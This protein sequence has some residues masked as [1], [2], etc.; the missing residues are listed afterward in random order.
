MNEYYYYTLIVPFIPK[1]ERQIIKKRD[2]HLLV[3]KS[4]KHR[5]I[6]SYIYIHVGSPCFRYCI[7]HYFEERDVINMYEEEYPRIL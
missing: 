6:N 1:S 2:L 5:I 3:L 4:H 7:C